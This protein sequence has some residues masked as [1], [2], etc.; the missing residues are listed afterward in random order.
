MTPGQAHA[1]ESMM[2]IYGF[3]YQKEMLDM[4]TLFGNNNPV[5][6]EIGFGMGESLANLAEA[7]E[8]WNFMGVDVHRPG[9]GALLA[10]VHEKQLSNIK[11]IEH[12][13]IDLFKRF[14][15]PNSLDMIQILYPDPWPKRRHHKR[16]LIQSSFLELILPAL[17]TNGFLFIA[18]DWKDYAKHIQSVLHSCAAL[19]SVDQKILKHPLLITRSQTKFQTRGLKK[20]HNIFEFFM[21]KN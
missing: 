16:R 4:Q 15:K 20:G 11:I 3:E 21:K 19:K 7:H 5:A 2:P 10:T 9:I 6:L 8:D 14:I 12:D 1:Y 18:T 17:K 13:A